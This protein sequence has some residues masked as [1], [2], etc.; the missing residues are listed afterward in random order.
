MKER[1]KLPEGEAGAAWF[2]EAKNRITVRLHHHRELELN[3]VLRGYAAYL[4]GSRR[5]TI[6]R[7]TLFWLFPGQEHLLMDLSPDFAMWVLVFAP[8]V[9]RR[10]C[11]SGDKSM[12]RKQAP[13]GDFGRV[14]ADGEIR[15]L[16]GLFREVAAASRVASDRHNAGLAFAL[17]S[18]WDAFRGTDNQP[19][20]TDMHPAVERA[21]R[22][23][24]EGTED[25]NSL[26]GLA[27]KVGL[28]AARLCRLFRRQVGV[29][30]SEFRSRQRLE[31]FLS[32]A[33]ERQGQTL[34]AMA[35][36]AGFGSYAQFHR[37]FRRC[38]GYSP[39]DG[40]FT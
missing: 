3:L 36:D 5:Y 11:R 21:V 16:N 32:L 4:V 26:T 37:V 28:S 10:E 38:L 19:R 18:A 30:I 6:E 14:L 13:R 40:Q 31:R 33:Q 22:L 12:L 20:Q 2:V 23:L 17:H 24:R 35:L 27:D 25:S 29:G 1:L 34:L 15:R 9:V 39:Q 8:D 7:G